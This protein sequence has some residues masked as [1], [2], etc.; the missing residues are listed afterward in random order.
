[1]FPKITPQFEAYI[2]PAR[3]HPQLWRLAAGLM[4]VTGIYLAFTIFVAG[5][6]ARLGGS[7]DRA[8]TPDGGPLATSA[9][10]FTFAGMGIG[11]G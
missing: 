7:L 9:V 3:T 1:M 11:V 6:A 8:F 2:A 10:L 4:L 5:Y